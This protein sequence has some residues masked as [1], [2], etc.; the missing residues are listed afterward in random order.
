MEITGLAADQ[1]LMTDRV[2]VE[3]IGSDGRR[4]KT[5]WTGGWTIWQGP[6]PVTRSSYLEVGVPAS[7]YLSARDTDVSAKADYSL[8]L[9]RLK[10]S[11]AI[12]AVNGD[13]RMPGLGWCKTRVGPFGGTVEVN[14]MEPG[15]EAACKASFL[16]NA[17]TGE[18]DP[19]VDGCRPDYAPAALGSEMMSRMNWY[20]NTYNAR[21]PRDERAYPVD[22]SKL[23]SARVVIRVYAPV[24]HFSYRVLIPHV[25]LSDWASWARPSELPRQAVARP[26]GK[27]E[28]PAK[29]R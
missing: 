13:E 17:E 4:L 10:T 25:K 15:L 1:V 11:Y 3:L 9:L 23:Q 6:Q 26:A 18:R 8:T 21:E 2:G 16:E 7:A 5:G 19:M 27:P 20:L 12:P 22:A 14:C 29:K 24:E 28:T